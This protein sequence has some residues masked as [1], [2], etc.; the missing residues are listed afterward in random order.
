[1][2]GNAPRTASRRRFL[3]GSAVAIASVGLT[4]CTATD[5]TSASGVP[6]EVDIGFC[7]D[8][9]FHHEQ[10]LAMC[11]RVLG[12]DTGGPVQNAAAELLQNQSYERGL[13]HAW[14]A[15]WGESTA[16][17]EEVMGW[18]GMSMPAA[19]MPGLATDQQMLRLAELTG[20]D[21]GRE[22]LEL[23]RTHHVGGIHMAESAAGDAS[24]AKVASLARQMSAQQT[25]EIEMYDTMLAT[26]YA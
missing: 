1:M 2:S 4:A 22:F 19:S 24:V 21:K 12:T 25:Y 3:L 8:M 14:L 7:T 10:A 5:S 9:A 17:P 16:P 6:N 13:M 23:M 26:T 11:Q 15:G 18:M 20:I